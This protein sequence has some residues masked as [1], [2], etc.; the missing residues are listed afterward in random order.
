[1]II[2]LVKLSS[3]DK[4][5]N[6]IPDLKLPFTHKSSS[7]FDRVKDLIKCEPGKQSTINFE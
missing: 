1:M 2:I 7:D 4:S 6:P 5:G 3:L